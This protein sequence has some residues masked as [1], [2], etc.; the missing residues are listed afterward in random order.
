MV[1]NYYSVDREIIGEKVVGGSRLDYLTDALGSISATVDQAGSVLNRYT[2]KPFGAVLQKTGTGPDPSFQWAGT[3]GYR[4]TRSKYSDVYIRARHYDTLNGK[5][6]TKDPIEYG[7]GLVSLYTYANNAPI[8]ATDPT[9]LYTIERDK[10]LS[11][12]PRF[13]GSYWICVETGDS[14]AV[15]A[16]DPV[17]RKINAE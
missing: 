12:N 3:H 1:T 6:A 7:N 17:S 8:R 9:G 10:C 2:Y 16:S 13:K 4:Q 15:A 5:W 11:V 14:T